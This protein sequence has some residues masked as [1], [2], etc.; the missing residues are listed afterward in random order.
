MKKYDLSIRV[1][2]QARE[3]LERIIKTHKKYKR[4]MYSHP[5]V[6]ARGRRE[7]EETFKENNPDVI[8]IKDGKKVKVSMRYEENCHNVH[9]EL[10][11]SVDGVPKDMRVI[12][13]LLEKKKI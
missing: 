2:P 1:S 13:R 5:N 3:E 9:Y 7:S 4:Y 11:V 8:F 10:D 6:T 12:N